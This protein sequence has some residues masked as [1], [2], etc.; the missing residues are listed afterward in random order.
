M[1][2][3]RLTLMS[4][5]GTLLMFGASSCSDSDEPT[6]VP[7]DG[8]D[9]VY[10]AIVDQ[11]LDNTVGITYTN[12][13]AKTELLVE[14]LKSLRDSK[15]DANVKEACDVF[16]DARAWWERSEAFLFGPASDFGIDPHIDSWPLDRDGLVAEMNNAAHIESMAAEDGDEW[17]GAHLGPELLG[18][19]GIEYILFAGG[20]P[21]AASDIP[22]NQL[23]Y[24]IAV[25]GDLHNKCFQLEVS[26]LGDSAPKSH[27]ERVEELEL[28]CTVLGG[29]D[30][31]GENMR[32]A[33]QAGS[34]YRSM[35][36][37]LQ[38][39]V[40]G[41]ASIVDEVGTQK[42]GKPHTGEDP[43]YIESPYSHKSITDFHDNM[44]S[45]KNAYMGGI[46]ERRDESKSI[47]NYIKGIDPEL[48][49]RCIAAIEG[50]LTAISRMKAPFV[51]NFRDPSAQTAMDACSELNEVLVE[52]KAALAK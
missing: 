5:F 2:I 7:G 48:D 46:E 43:N 4:L 22:D 20:Q 23:I 24:A 44:I 32:R 38:A 8:R 52:V 34:T 9:E 31:Y 51:D 10:S 1:K 25:A 36:D 27:V 14:K 18:F 26:W 42:I 49:A 35:T 21:K 41:C 28:N 13:A 33:G 30:S 6:P 40:D 11:Y 3:N 19:H 29:D 15:T 47:H 37:A 16:L 17:A 39:I 50:A 45:V 12:L